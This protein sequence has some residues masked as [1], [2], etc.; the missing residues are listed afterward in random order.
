[1]VDGQNFYSQFIASEG[2]IEKGEV[3]PWREAELVEGDPEPADGGVGNLP[4]SAALRPC[5][6]SQAHVEL[7]LVGRNNAPCLFLNKT[8]FKLETISINQMVK[9]TN[10]LNTYL[11]FWEGGV[12]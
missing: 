2:V 9:G 4:D 7:G 6:P 8:V 5:L 10:S 1:V 12:L 11:L 3:G